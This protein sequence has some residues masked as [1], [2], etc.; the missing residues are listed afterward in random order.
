MAEPMLEP[1]CTK[2]TKVFVVLTALTRLVEIVPDGVLPSSM[3]RWSKSKVAS[4][5]S[6]TVLLL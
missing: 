5:N 2:V 4:F 6:V 3:P 1:T